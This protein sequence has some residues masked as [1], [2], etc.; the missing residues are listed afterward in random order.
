MSFG[1]ALRPAIVALILIA[2]NALTVPCARAS[3][4][5]FLDLAAYNAATMTDGVMTFNGASG[6]SSADLPLYTEGAATLR[7]YAT[8]KGMAFN[9]GAVF[10]P[11]FNGHSINGTDYYVAYSGFGASQ[12]HDPSNGYLEFTLTHKCRAAGITMASTYTNKG[13]SSQLTAHI[14][15]Y[16]GDTLVFAT[17]T[18]GFPDFLTATPNRRFLGAIT[19]VPFDRVV[20]VSK[21]VY[22]NAFVVADNFRYG[23][24]VAA[25]FIP[26]ESVLVTP[27][28]SGP[29]RTGGVPVA[30]SP[31]RPQ[32]PPRG[33]GP[34][35]NAPPPPRRVSPP[36][37]PPTN[38]ARGKWGGPAPGFIRQNTVPQGKVKKGGGTGR[39]VTGQ[40]HP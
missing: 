38:N 30:G 27:G 34:P 9:Y 11:S 3:G 5:E 40:R 18:Y 8:D 6:G 35:R 37:P 29:Y 33:F 24:L 20:V 7:S 28:G 21:G 19:N 39:S 13:A 23:S 12:G 17:R 4:I 10:S 22:D 32:T 16:D 25:R 36:V 15:Y 1:N 2:F 26:G 31:N 14:E